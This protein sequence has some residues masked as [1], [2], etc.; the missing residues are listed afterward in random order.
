MRCLLARCFAGGVDWNETADLAAG[1]HQDK[2]MIQVFVSNVADRRAE[3]TRFNQTNPSND[4]QT[5][6]IPEQP[7]TIGIKFGQKF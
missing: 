4:N 7:R 3:L 1:V 6:I 2:M 5:Y